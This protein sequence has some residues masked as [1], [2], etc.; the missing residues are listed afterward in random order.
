MAAIIKIFLYFVGWG[1]F[2]GGSLGLLSGTLILPL[3]GFFFSTLW[4][5]P[6]GITLGIVAGL[7]AV[8]AQ[9]CVQ[10]EGVKDFILYRRRLSWWIGVFTAVAATAPFLVVATVSSFFNTPDRFIFGSPFLLLS[11]VLHSALWGGLAAAYTTSRAVDLFA[12]GGYKYG[13]PEV[14]MEQK[15]FLW[16]VRVHILLGIV[17]GA[18]TSLTGG[19]PLSEMSPSDAIREFIIGFT[20]GIPVSMFT[21]FLMTIANANLIRF[22]NRLVFYEYFPHLSQKTYKRTLVCITGMFTLLVCFTSL[23]FPYWFF[24]APF[25]ALASATSTAG[26]ADKYWTVQKK[27]HPSAPTDEWDDSP[28][29]D[30][31]AASVRK[32]Q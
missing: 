8:I 10:I 3:G 15:A 22:L 4:G 23:L 12:K 28:F 17:I 27:H 21:G 7:I 2:Y 13:L 20:I 24:I 11:V 5:V 31:Y 19:V 32:A 25:I 26:Y 1:F 6:I 14:W 29:E 16:K 30:E 18:I 9:Q